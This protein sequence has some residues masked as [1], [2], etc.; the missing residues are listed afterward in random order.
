M[1]LIEE[2]RVEYSETFKKR[3]L[4]SSLT[5]YEVKNNGVEYCN[6][7]LK[8]K[9]LKGKT[10]YRPQSTIIRIETVR[11]QRNAWS[12]EELPTTVHDNKD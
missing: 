7:I 4:N 12:E 6:N 2:E 9:V 10:S 11:K 3:S 1:Q 5:Y 8:I